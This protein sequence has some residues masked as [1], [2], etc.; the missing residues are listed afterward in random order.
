MI[1]QRGRYAIDVKRKWLRSGN[2]KTLAFQAK[3]AGSIPA[4]RS[5]FTRPVAQARRSGPPKMTG[6]VM[7]AGHF[8]AS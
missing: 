7:N 1:A 4:A 5:T 6:L 3:D 2:G 8:G